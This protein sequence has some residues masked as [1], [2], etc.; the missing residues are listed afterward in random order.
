MA[1]KEFREWFLRHNKVTTGDKPDQEANFVKI[2]LVKGV[3]KFMTFLRDDVP[4]ENAFRKLFDSI[5]F[6]LNKEDTATNTLQGL[7]KK[8]TDTQSE[9]RLSNPNSD[10]TLGVVPHQLPEVVLTIDGS[11]SVVGPLVEAGGLK[12]TNIRRTL[13]GLFRRNYKLEVNAVNS[14]EV[15]SGTK[16]IQLV[17]DELTPDNNFFYGKRAGVKGWFKL[18]LGYTNIRLDDIFSKDNDNLETIT[19]G[20]R[21]FVVSLEAGKS[22][23]I[24]AVLFIN[25]QNT[26][27]LKIGFTAS[28]AV[29]NIIADL[30]YAATSTNTIDL[31]ARLVAINTSA[32]VASLGNGTCKIVGTVKTT[33]A[34]DIELQFA[35]SVTNVS[36]STIRPGSYFAIEE[37][38][39]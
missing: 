22:Y 35:Q 10:F 25:P 4:S 37:F 29:S 2:Y 9:S 8:S 36:P 34:V 23:K 39:S 24:E 3:S 19:D 6:K 38:I 20:V 14:V 7:I 18:P 21:E 15:N 28:G 13:A 1:V 12:L 17:N 11:D 32:S 30:Q 16:K 26:G 31:K 33:G 5:T 27:G